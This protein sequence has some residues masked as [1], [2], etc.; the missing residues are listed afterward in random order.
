MKR[1]VGFF[2]AGLGAFLLVLAA[3]LKLYVVPNLAKAPLVPGEDTD[4]VNISINEGTAVTLFNPAALAT[5]DDPIRRNVP[6]V[7]TRYTRGDV[8]ASETSEATSQN[9]AVYDS[10]SR[11][12]DT[13]DTVLS[14]ETIRVP[15]NRTTSVLAN[16][17]GGNVD[18]EDVE[19]SGINPLKFP[20][21]VEKKSY[22]YFDTTILKALPAEFVGEEE[23][24]GMNTYKFQQVIPP[25]PY[26]TI[27]VPGSLV[28]SAEATV[29]GDRVYANTR[30]LW[31]DPV[32]G[33]VIKGYE[34]Q[35]QTLQVDGQ[36]KLVLVEANVGGTDVE[37]EKTVKATESSANLLNA[38]NSTVPLVAGILGLL[39]LLGGILLARRPKQ[40]EDEIAYGYPPAPPTE[41]A[42]APVGAAAAS[43]ASTGSAAPASSSVSPPTEPIPAV[44]PQAYEPSAPEPVAPESVESAGESAASAADDAAS[45]ENAADAVADAPNNNA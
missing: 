20:F 18:G 30:T 17:C 8:Q 29:E 28:G 38:M 21:F 1:V 10:F 36:D 12:T 15:F 19:F 4:G 9:L 22:D 27:E 26:T 32:T 33:S 3:M 31:V 7:S 42:A 16:C 34:Q 24:F 14:A 45:V 13:D 5:G 39:A 35:K 40:D 41:F 43:A 25:T 11:L 23:L 44:P 6:V 37:V 2:L